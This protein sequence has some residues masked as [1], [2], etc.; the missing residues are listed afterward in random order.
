[1]EYAPRRPH[2]SLM[3]IDAQTFRL[4]LGQFVTGVTVIAMDVDGDV[5]AMTVNSFTSVSLEPPLVLFCAGKDSKMG[6]F[7]DEAT[8]FSVSILTQGQQDVSSY[9]AGAWTG[10]PPPFSFVPWIG[11]PRLEGSAAAIGCGL[12]AVHDGGDHWIVVGRVLAT[13]RTTDPREPLTYYGG[14]YRALDPDGGR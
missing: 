4:T 5:R 14:R 6:R 2:P 3:T 9:F 1:M 7:A 8:G 10:A 11:G 12:H 13:H